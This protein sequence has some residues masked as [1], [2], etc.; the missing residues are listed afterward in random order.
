MFKDNTK[1]EYIAPEVEIIRL[2]S[3]Q[4]LLQSSGQGGGGMP[5]GMP[6]ESF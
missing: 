3:S 4:A 2:E 5:G 6:G 1:Q